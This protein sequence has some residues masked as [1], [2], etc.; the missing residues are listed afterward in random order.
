MTAEGVAAFLFER[1]LL[2]PA[3]L[4]RNDLRIEEVPGRN[5]NFRVHSAGGPGYFVKRCRPGDR[6]EGR[7]L[8]VEADF[9]AWVGRS[10]SGSRLRPYVPR[11]CLFDSEA[12]TLVLELMTD[13]RSP[14]P[15]NV[16][17]SVASA[18]AA[19]HA[20]LDA[21]AHDSAESDSTRFL[22]T[23][24]PWAL[25][26]A[27]PVPE[28]LRDLAPAQVHLLKLIQGDV[29][30]CASLDA[31]RTGWSLS[32]LI[33]GDIKWDNMLIGSDSPNE[34][35]ASVTLVDWELARIGDPAWDVGSVF[36]SYLTRCVLRSPLSER[37]EAVSAAFGSALGVAR[38]ETR[39]F[40][41]SYTGATKLHESAAVEFLRKS[42]GHCAARLLQS[43]YE[44]SQRE[45]SMTRGTLCLLQLAF[46]ML[47]RPHAAAADVLGITIAS[48]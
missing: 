24:P 37:P 33:H 29:A 36:H 21:S 32:G 14:D 5:R 12:G 25:E 44:W 26:I 18:L 8:R 10:A 27:K 4:V 3:R 20:A 34:P 38:K 45:A 17:I 23:Q 15:P 46:N 28:A 19:C 31:L 7:L 6:S 35:S 16:P 48:A 22:P 43:A 9:Y 41:F 39:A 30:I 2:E 47:R 42:V 40:W 13:N 11:L 1:R